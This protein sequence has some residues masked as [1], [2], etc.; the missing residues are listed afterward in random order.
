MRRID[1]LRYFITTALAQTAR[2]GPITGGPKYQ[3]WLLA[4]GRA[5]PR[6]STGLFLG[7][8]AA[9]GLYA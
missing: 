1:C 9:F 6:R 2:A 4:P 3:A 5:A 8:L 7:R